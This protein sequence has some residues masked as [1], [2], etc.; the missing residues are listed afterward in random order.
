[1]STVGQRERNTQD[2]VVALFR[3]ELG[4]RYLG[5]WIDRDDNRNIEDELL[6]RWLEGQG[7]NAS[8]ITRAIHKLKQAAALGGGTSLYEANRAV[9]ELLRYG[10]KVKPGAGEHAVT[11]DLIDW[12]N[13]S[14][15]DFAVAEEVTVPADNPKRPD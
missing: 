7:V 2:R 10:V 15:N 14:A 6:S 13:P 4:Y 9:Y 12:D 8:L 1:M 5:D 11:V 3:G